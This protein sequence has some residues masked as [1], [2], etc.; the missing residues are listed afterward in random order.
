MG[1]TVIH[2]DVQQMYKTMNRL[3]AGKIF[4]A[5]DKTDYRKKDNKLDRYIDLKRLQQSVKRH[6]EKFPDDYLVRITF[7][8]KSYLP[9]Q[10]HIPFNKYSFEWRRG[11]NIIILKI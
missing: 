10:Q 8:G 11:D 3:E 1:N 7:V 5:M 6:K 4:N 9:T 2:P